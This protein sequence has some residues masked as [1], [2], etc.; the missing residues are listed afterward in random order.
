MKE[1]IIEK[2]N[3]PSLFLQDND[4]GNI[5]E[6]AR[7]CSKI[8]ESNNV[9]VLE[10]SSSCVVLRPSEITAIQVTESKDKVEDDLDVKAQPTVEL[11]VQE[12]KIIEDIITDGEDIIMDG[13]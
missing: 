11:D 8:L 9:S 7:K 4:D 1:I 12:P 10:T 3:G 2:K 6:Y 5:V 13:D